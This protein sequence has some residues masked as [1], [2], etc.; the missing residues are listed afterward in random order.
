MLTKMINVQDVCNVE[1][2]EVDTL[3]WHRALR[4]N[5]KLDI[6]LDKK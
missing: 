5:T 3:V 2:V 6:Y 1:N 4:S